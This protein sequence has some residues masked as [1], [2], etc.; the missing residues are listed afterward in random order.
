MKG[1][2]KDTVVERNIEDTV[3]ELPVEYAEVVVGH[4]RTL[5]QVIATDHPEIR[6]RTEFTTKGAVQLLSTENP[7]KEVKQFN[8][9]TRF[10]RAY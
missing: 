1:L 10:A 4:L 5:G 7:T 8:E 9:I 6:V 3:K 2:L